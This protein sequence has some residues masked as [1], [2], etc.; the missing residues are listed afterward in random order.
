MMEQYNFDAAI[1]A[2]VDEMQKEVS[3]KVLCYEFYP[4]NTA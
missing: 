1:T 2:S 4:F 3:I